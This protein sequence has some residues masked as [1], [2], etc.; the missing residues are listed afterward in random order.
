MA[1]IVE[2]IGRVRAKKLSCIEA[3]EWLGISERH[4]RRLRD[5]YEEGGAA[6]I[7]DRRRGRP[8]SNKASDDAVDFVSEQYRTRYFDFTPNHVCEALRKAHTE[9]RYGYIRPR[10]WSL[11]SPRR[12]AI[13]D[14]MKSWQRWQSQSC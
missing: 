9:F 14:W 2:A 3:A 13:S 7:V 4:F 11:G 12:T 6:A 8:A 10:R 5:G 1:R